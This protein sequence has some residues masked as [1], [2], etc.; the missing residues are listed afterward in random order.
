LFIV[1]TAKTNLEWSRE[2]VIN[3]EKMRKRIKA[4]NFVSEEEAKERLGF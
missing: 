1:E 3:I 4:D 2:A